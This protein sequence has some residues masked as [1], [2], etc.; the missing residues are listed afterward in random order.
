M[1]LTP[2]T[3]EDCEVG[4]RLLDVLALPLFKHALLLVQRALFLVK[5]GLALARSGTPMDVA[6][7]VIVFSVGLIFLLDVVSLLVLV[8]VKPAN[9]RAAPLVSFDVV[10]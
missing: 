1:L 3:H 6:L 9:P 2:S 10:A 7:L 5:H 8:D 4:A